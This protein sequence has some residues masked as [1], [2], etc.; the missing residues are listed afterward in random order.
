MI[1]AIVI[2][3]NHSFD[4]MVNTNKINANAPMMRLTCIMI[5]AFLCSF[6]MPMSLFVQFF[7]FFLPVIVGVGCHT[8]CNYSAYDRRP[9]AVKRNC[10][11]YQKENEY[12]KCQTYILHES[13][14]LQ[15]GFSVHLFK[16]SL[17]VFNVSALAL[18]KSSLMRSF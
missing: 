17:S 8:A 12:A 2:A 1:N 5:L 13:G 11:D 3:E 9:M 15:F 16:K 4:V 7:V 18:S 6:E 14:M 10:G